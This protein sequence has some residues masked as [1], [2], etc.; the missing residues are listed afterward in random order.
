MTNADQASPQMRLTILLVVVACLFGA[1]FARLWFLQVINAPQAQAVA[2]DNGIRTIYTPAPRGLILDRNG[3]VL[4]GNVNEPVIEVNRQVASQNP[5]M[6]SRLAPLLGMTVKQLNT[7]INN[8]QFSPYAPVPVQVDATPEQIL[9][10]QENQ[11]QFPGVEATS[12]SVRNYSPLG[13]TAANIVGYVGQISSVQLA[14]LKNQG[15]QAGDQ[16]GLAGIEAE[17]ES[18]LRGSPGTEKVQV[19]SKGN[20]LGTLS[21]TQPVP[22]DNIRLTIDGTVQAV[23]QA[24]IAQGQIAA[25]HTFDP[26]TKRDFSAPAGSA[27]VE[28]P[29]SGQIV[30]LATNPSYDPS[31]FVGGISKANYDALLNNPSDPLVDRSIQ[32]QYAPGSTFKLIT[33]IAGL[34]NGIINPSTW[35]NDTGRLQIGNFPAHN[36]NYEAYGPIQLAQAITV[37]SDLFFNKIGLDLWYGRS[38]YGDDALQKVAAAFG[39]GKPSGID[40]PNEA[41][42]KIPTPESYVKDHQ[43]HPNIFSQAQWYPGNSDQAAI[44]QDE[45][46]VTPLQLA[47]AYSCFANGGTLYQPILVKDAET[48]G[49]KVVKEFA[50]KVLDKVQ[51]Q[52]DWRAAMIAGFDGVTHAAK[53]TASSVFSGTPLDTPAI[54]IAGKTGTAQVNPPRQN[55]SVFTSF[56]PASS[57]RYVVDAFMEQ[58]GYGASVAAPVVREIYAALYGLPPMPV[59][60]S[61]GG[62]GGQN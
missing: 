26:V 7:A 48:Q 2:A 60:Y 33:A 16:I 12:M 22:G 53:G 13:M 20:V 58:A 32:G 50:G 9:Y 18:Y 5:Q 30:A 10:V 46:L 1:L 62:S 55:T 39:L 40:L 29:N 23:A 59:T 4:V 8:L 3:K 56:S 61:S 15:Y 54:D 24:A 34:Q 44:G 52:P 43:A 6:V 42:G 36:D 45:D 35:F 38:Q 19:D 27:V 25:Q 17:Y 21:T 31:L 41:P 51:I 57:P 11:A 49:G 37:S 47:N 14:K 28:D